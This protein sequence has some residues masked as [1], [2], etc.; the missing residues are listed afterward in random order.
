MIVMK[1]LQK[2]RINEDQWKIGNNINVILNEMKNPGKFKK[3]T[4]LPRRFAPV[5]DVIN[6]NL[7]EL[8]YI[9]MR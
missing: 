2:K 9:P 3:N 8:S 5:D 1:M 4:G 7:Q 6:F